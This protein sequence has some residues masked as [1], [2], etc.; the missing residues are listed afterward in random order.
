MKRD[1]TGKEINIANLKFGQVADSSIFKKEAGS[2]LIL[3]KY[4]LVPRFSL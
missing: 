1:F 2:E 4:K 3:D